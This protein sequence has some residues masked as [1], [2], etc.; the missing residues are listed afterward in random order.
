MSAERT[1]RLAALRSWLERDNLDGFILPRGDEHLGEYVAPYAERLAWLT[2]FTGSAGAAVVLRDA[3][4]AFSDGRYTLQLAMQVDG[5]D[6][7]RHHSGQHPPADW[8]AA[9]ASQAGRTLRVAFDPWLLSEDSV[10]LNGVLLPS[11]GGWS[12]Q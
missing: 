9:R 3:A 6:W 5:N 11:D 1:E 2:G 10:N 7:E 8:L 12:V 4:A